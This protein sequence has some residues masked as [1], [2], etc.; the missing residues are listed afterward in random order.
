MAVKRSLDAQNDEPELKRIKTASKDC[1]KCGE[2]KTLDQYGVRTKGAGGLQAVCKAC[3]SIANKKYNN[4]YSGFLNALIYHSR[5]AVQRKS[6][7]NLKSTLT[8]EK[9]K[10]LNEDQNGLCAISGATLVFRSFSNNQA[11]VDRINDE[12]GYVD[13]NCRLV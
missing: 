7:R 6:A 10:T 11:S 2:S 3:A 4:T 8:L 13:G 5:T 9:L 1:S 12:F